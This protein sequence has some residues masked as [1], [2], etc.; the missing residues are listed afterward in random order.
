[1]E[2]KEKDLLIWWTTQDDCEALID[3]EPFKVPTYISEQFQSRLGRSGRGRLWIHDTI[4]L[5]RIDW[6][7]QS[8]VSELCERSAGIVFHAEDIDFLNGING[9]ITD[10]NLIEIDETK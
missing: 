6:N 10:L 4:K 9:I 7:E 5:K 8:P 2:T 3:S 1:M